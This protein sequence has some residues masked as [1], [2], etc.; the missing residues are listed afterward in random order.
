LKA[1]QRSAAS[2]ALA[3][4]LLSPSQSFAATLPPPPLNPALGNVSVLISGPPIKDAR[5]L[6][7]NA[8]P[9]Q[10]KAIKEVQSA[11]ESITDDLKLPGTKGFDQV[12]G[13]S[14]F[15]HLLSSLFSALCSTAIQ[16]P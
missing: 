10:G 12:A 14:N 9:I 13:V 8:L 15:L 3:L 7:R 4:T 5:T 11:L 16:R 6:L 1:L 2:A